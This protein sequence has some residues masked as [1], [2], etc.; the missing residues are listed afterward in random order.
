MLYSNVLKSNISKST[1]TILKNDWENFKYTLDKLELL[2]KTFNV[3]VSHFASSWN[4]LL[5]IIYTIHY[6]P[7]Y[8]D[9]AEEIK[10]YLLRAILFTY[11]QSGTTGKLNTLKNMLNTYDRKFDRRWLDNDIRALELTDSKIEDILN[12]QKKIVLQTKFCFT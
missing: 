9:N 2:L 10:I 3:E 11:F 6:N 5:P 4:V 7:N 8:E 12:S 1:A